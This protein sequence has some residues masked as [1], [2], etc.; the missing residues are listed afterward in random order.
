MKLLSKMKIL[1]A[2]LGLLS[3]AVASPLRLESNSTSVSQ[4]A[5][6][7]LQGSQSTTPSPEERE[8]KQCPEFF[9]FCRWCPEDYRCDKTPAYFRPKPKY[10][11]KR[12]STA[13][14]RG[15]D[16][17]K[18]D[19]SIVDQDKQSVALTEPEPEI[20]E[21]RK[22]KNT[23]PK[24]CNLIVKCKWCPKDPRCGA[25]QAGWDLEPFPR[26]SQFTPQPSSHSITSSSE[27]SQAM[28]QP[29]ISSAT[30]SAEASQSSRSHSTDEFQV[31]KPCTRPQ[32]TAPGLNEPGA[33]SGDQLVQSSNELQPRRNIWPPRPWPP[34]PPIPNTQTRESAEADEPVT[35]A[36]STEQQDSPQLDSR[37]IYGPFRPPHHLDPEISNGAEPSLHVIKNPVMSIDAHHRFDPRRIYGPSQP[38]HLPHLNVQTSA[39]PSVDVLEDP[40]Q[41]TE[42]P[43]GPHTDIPCLLR[44]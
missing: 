22:H 27:D 3:V 37:R 5:S 8:P 4:P 10:N 28:P 11:D 17:S 1:C 24:L 32:C 42:Q 33:L 6:T 34:H 44:P 38:P 20:L 15:L 36:Q 39:E 21:K 19:D 25:G 9:L 23:Y 16:G 12:S 14:E 43:C 2:L 29:S 35:S 30:K 18:P 7:G 26:R 31:Y 41:S 13:G 40:V